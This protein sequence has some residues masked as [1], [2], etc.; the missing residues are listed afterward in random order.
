MAFEHFDQHP[1][2]VAVV[3][4]NGAGKSTF[5]NAF[6][7]D[8]GLPFVNADILAQELEIDAY[9]AASVAGTI[10][11][12]FVENKTSFIFETVFSDP[13]GE[14]LRFFEDAVTAGYTVLLC[15]IRISNAL[16][17]D[18]RVTMRVHKGGHDV[19][20]EKLKERFPR[21]LQNLRLAIQRLPQIIVYDNDDLSNPFQQVAVFEDGRIVESV[22]DLPSWLANLL[23]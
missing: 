16:I 2:L 11:Q 19:P 7:S 4:S 18:E 15:F 22:G 17:S 21:T 8:T 6:L 12:G 10:R 5:Y 9:T 3:G 14:K 13:V 1:I 20:I 23:H